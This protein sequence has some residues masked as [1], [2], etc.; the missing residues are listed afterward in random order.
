MPFRRDCP[1]IVALRA[2]PKPPAK[3]SHKGPND[4]WAHRV[5]V[6][7]EAMT[8]AG[9]AVFIAG[10]PMAAEGTPYTGFLYAGLMIASDGTPKV[11]EFNCRFGDPETQPILFRLR[12]DLLELVEAA[13]DGKLNVVAADW[14]PRIAVGVVLAAGGYPE[15]YRKGDVIDGLPASPPEH[16]KVFHAGTRLDDG[17]V[18]TSGG[19]V[20]CAVALGETTAE[21]QAEA[22]ELVSRIHWPDVYYRTDIGYR[23]VARERG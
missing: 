22:Y 13:L 15:S 6:R 3:G 9:D 12:S 18:L 17:Q 5:P 20:L 7:V 1:T 10:P 16:L 2:D 14:D 4:L 11:L 23:A 19:R 21:A 8:L